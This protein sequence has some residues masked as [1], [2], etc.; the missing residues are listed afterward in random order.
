MSPKFLSK[1][2]TDIH[3]QA[4]SNAIQY[5]EDTVYENNSLSLMAKDGVHS[6]I[7]LHHKLLS[8]T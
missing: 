3:D 1:F 8:D 6:I 4:V 7:K 2:M 5:Y